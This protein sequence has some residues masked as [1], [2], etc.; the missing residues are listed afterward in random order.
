MSS[1]VEAVRVAFIKEEKRRRYLRVEAALAEAQGNLGLIPGDAAR[2]IARTAR[3]LDL[4]PGKISARIAH[5]G[6]SMMA[7]IE[8]LSDAVGE[9]GS[10]VHWGATTQNI[11]QTGDVLILRDVHATVIEQIREAMEAMADLGERTAAT[12]MAG[13][14]HWQHAVPITF[15]LKVAAWSDQLLRHHE[16]LEQ[17]APR[18]LQSMTGGAAG[19]FAS[20][21]PLGVELQAEVA[22]LLGLAPMRVPSRAIVDHLAEFV[23]VLGLAAA[24]CQSVFEEIQRLNTSEYGEAHEAAPAENVGSSTMPQKRVAP[25]LGV[26]VIAAASAR[27]AAPLALEAIIQ[28]HEVD[29]TRSVMMDRALEQAC[30]CTVEALE[31]LVGLA[32]SLEI[33]PERMRENLEL[34]G[35]LVNAEAVMLHLAETIGRQEAHHAVHHAVGQV[36]A[37]GASFA[38]ALLADPAVARSMTREQIDQLIDPENYTGLSEQI[39]R[40]AAIRARETAGRAPETAGGAP[41]TAGRAPEP[42]G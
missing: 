42:A 26:G 31:N 13:R 36:T 3:S 16:R 21:G 10:W 20:F 2:A 5:H 41:E 7:L 19:T 35:G 37:R 38:D 14:A 40:E 23:L 9:Y 24:T 28:S 4:D 1:R 32:R 12:P 27:A 39:A 17:L 6:H 25:H 8:V 34:T 33:S 30:V 22:R 11:Q 15:G 18:L 29:G